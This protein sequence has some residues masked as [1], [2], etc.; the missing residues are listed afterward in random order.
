MLSESRGLSGPSS[1]RCCSARRHC[2]ITPGL[3]QG[4]TAIP[5]VPPKNHRHSETSALVLT[6]L[7]IGK[8]Y[9][10]P[11]VRRRIQRSYARFASPPHVNGSFESAA[12]SLKSA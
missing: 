4:G 12:M 11:R 2:S 7:S 9:L 1:E 5:I 10:L 8:P 3:W 6:Q